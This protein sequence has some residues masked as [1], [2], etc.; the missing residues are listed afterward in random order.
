[1]NAQLYFTQARIGQ[2]QDFLTASRSYYVEIA[3]KQRRWGVHA[4]VWFDGSALLVD[5]PVI[6]VVQDHY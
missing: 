4:E 2:N 1:M 5:G 6:Y 3:V